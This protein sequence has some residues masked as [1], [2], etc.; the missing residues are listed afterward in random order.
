MVRGPGPANNSH[1]LG[2]MPRAPM[3]LRLL[4]PGDVAGLVRLWPAPTRPGPA[5]HP[6]LERAIA[7][8]RAFGA[9]IVADSSNAPLAS[10]PSPCVPPAWIRAYHARPRQALAVALLEAER[11][12]QATMLDPEEVAAANT[13]DEGLHAVVL[14]YCQ[15][16]LDPADPLT[17]ET[18]AIGHAGHLQAHAGY[19]LHAICQKASS[20]EE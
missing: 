4:E 3:H 6:T 18:L 7:A 1:E 12:T 2:Y 14:C 11:D 16:H 9:C 13:G 17:H 20:R 8:G 5:L 10:G 15:R 19:H